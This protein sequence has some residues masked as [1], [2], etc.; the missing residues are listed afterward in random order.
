MTNIRRI[1]SSTGRPAQHRRSPSAE[2]AEAAQH[3]R[4]RHGSPHHMHSTGGARQR[5]RSPSTTTGRPAPGDRHRQRMKAGE[6]EKGKGKRGTKKRERD[7]KPC[8]VS[9]YSAGTTPPTAPAAPGQ[10]AQRHRHHLK[11]CLSA[12]AAILLFLLKTG[13]GAPAPPEINDNKGTTAGRQGRRPRHGL[14]FLD[15]WI[16]YISS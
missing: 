12:E 11:P 5:R 3:R 14:H 4:S 16:V 9:I 8:T 6:D 2:A 13:T 15:H 1:W 10:P 7:R